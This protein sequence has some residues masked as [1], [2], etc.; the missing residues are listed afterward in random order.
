VDLL[1]PG[2][3]GATGEGDA[4]S[5]FE[6]LTGGSESD[7]LRG[8]DG[9]NRIEGGGVSNPNGDVIDGAGGDDELTGTKA[10]D[11]I[12]GGAGDDELDGVR[13]PDRLSGGPGD[14]DI[15][16]F[17]QERATRDRVSCGTGSDRA[18][19]PDRLDAIGSDCETV[20]VAFHSLVAMPRRA[21]GSI[22]FRFRRDNSAD[23]NAI[24]CG[25]IELGPGGSLGRLRFTAPRR[26]TKYVRVPLT[27]RGRRSDR[28]GARIALRFTAYLTC[29][30]AEDDTNGTGAYT[31][32]R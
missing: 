10:V 28:P 17:H 3:D 13:G 23:P 19:E 31:L 20:T 4:V 15:D 5:G 11:R 29:P 12:S 26:G 2:P 8:T 9:P 18:W 24:R 30:G 27:A 1:D 22:V 6:N 32:R 25:L 14:D 21:G 7:V 16:L